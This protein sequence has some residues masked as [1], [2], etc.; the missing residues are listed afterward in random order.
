MMRRIALIISLLVCAC[1]MAQTIDFEDGRSH[2]EADILIGLNNDGYEFA[3]GAAYFPFDFIGLKANIGAAGEIESVEDWGVEDWEKTRDYTTRFKFTPALVLR[4]PPLAQ[5][6]RIGGTFHLFA[7]PGLSLSP[8]A[9]G[10]RG[11]RWL[12]WDFKGGVNLQ[13]DR[14]IVFIGYGFS[15]FSLY[16]GF[17][18]TSNYTTHFGFIGT[19][20]KF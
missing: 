16:S 14:A 17:P 5:W 10:S 9:S 19:A 6:K 15:S 7:E 20:Y 12:N 13:I 18:K 11:A 8:G 1:S 3:L 2:W 4:T